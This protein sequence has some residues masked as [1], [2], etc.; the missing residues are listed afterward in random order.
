MQISV[1]ILG[2]HAKLKY[3]LDSFGVG[4]IRCVYARASVK[5]TCHLISQSQTSIHYSSVI[6]VDYNKLRERHSLNIGTEL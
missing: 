1:R 4:A 2:Y 3:I 6:S 5:I